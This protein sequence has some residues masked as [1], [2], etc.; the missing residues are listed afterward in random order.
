MSIELIISLVFI[1]AVTLALVLIA[2]WYLDTHMPGSAPGPKGVPFFF[3][4]LDIMKNKHRIYDWTL[5]QCL[6]SKSLI[7]TTRISFFTPRTIT[8]C[9]PKAVEY[10][11]KDNFSNYIKGDFFQEVAHD[12]FGTGIFNTNGSN[13]KSQRQ[14]KFS[15][16]TPRI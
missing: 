9:E 13:W 7:W 5:D 2:H 1:S 12:F 10:I 8:V 11:L 3:N 16:S 6:E 14:A 15:N 4:F